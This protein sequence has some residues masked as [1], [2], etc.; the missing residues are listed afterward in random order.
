MTK[1]IVSYHRTVSTAPYENMKVGLDMEFDSEETPNR[2]VAWQ[3]VRA[4][5]EDWL[6]IGMTSV[7]VKS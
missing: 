4:L 3:T 1:Y 6:D 2:N 5:V 7:R